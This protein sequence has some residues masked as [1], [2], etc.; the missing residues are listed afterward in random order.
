MDPYF[1]QRQQRMA[2]RVGNLES[3]LYVRF[4]EARKANFC[5]SSKSGTRRMKDPFVTWLGNPPLGRFSDFVL[6]FIARE[7]IAGI[8]DDAATLRTLVSSFALMR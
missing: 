7:T 4:T 5:F 3:N 6:A 8:T 2:K 1:D